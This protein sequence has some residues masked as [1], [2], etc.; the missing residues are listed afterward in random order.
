[1]LV[2]CAGVFTA[3]Q[4]QKCVVSSYIILTIVL[5]VPGERLPVVGVAP[6]VYCVITRV[7]LRSGAT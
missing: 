4:A 6:V 3:I 5:R 2:W 7:I 1:V